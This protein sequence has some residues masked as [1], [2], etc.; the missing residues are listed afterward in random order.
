MML[1]GWINFI[2]LILLAYRQI[3]RWPLPVLERPLLIAALL[4]FVLI[5]TGHTLSLFTQLGN[6]WLTCSVSLAW[7]CGS[8]AILKKFAPINQQPAPLYPDFGLSFYRFT[9]PQHERMVMRLMLV[10]LGIAALCSLILVLNNNAGNADSISYRLPRAFW[11]VSHHSLLHPFDYNDRRVLFYPLNG[12]LLYVPL[13]TY[14]FPGT[15]HNIPTYLAW[16]VVGLTVYRGGR[17]MGA[18]RA[19]SLLATALITLT[20]NILVQ[21]TATNDEIL[22]GSALLLAVYA[23]IRWL[24]SDQSLYLIMAATLAGISIGT[25]LHIVFYIPVLLLAALLLAIAAWRYPARARI[26]WQ[27]IGVPRL[28]ACLALGTAM[29]APFV[30]Y[31]YASSG[32]FYFTDEFAGDFFNTHWKLRVFGQNTLI[33]LAELIFAPLGDLYGASEAAVRESFHASLNGFFKPLIEPYLSNNPADYHL[34]YRFKGV[35]LP[36]SPYYLEYSLWAGFGFLLVP[37]VWWQ[38]WRQRHQ[39]FG[40]AWLLLGFAPL[41]WFVTW[42]ASTLYMEGTP[43]YLAYYLLISAPSLLFAFMPIAGKWQNRLR[44]NLVALVLLTHL[45]IDINIYRLNEF[46]N[47]PRLFTASRLPYDWELMDQ[48]VINEIKGAQRIHLAYTR[49]GMS[50]FGIMQHNPHAF[51]D[52]PNETVTD[53]DKTLTIF[54]VPS[55][56]TWGF[57]PLYVA[58]KPQPGATFIGKMRGWGS[59]GVF[60]VGDGVAQRWPDRNRYVFFRIQMQL[61]PTELGINITPYSPGY[62]DPDIL[63]TRYEIRRGKELVAVRDWLANPT[64]NT[65]I[66]SENGVTIAPT[67]TIIARVPGVAG[68]EVSTQLDLTRTHEWTDDMIGVTPWIGN[69]EGGD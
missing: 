5:M 25:K 12:T 56:Q 36:V 65:A 28:I 37:L 10:F 40:Y 1:L 20:P 8:L 69:K 50:Y 27:K 44:W 24:R 43:T 29:I 45:I 61:A 31:N 67:I 33:Y 49:W 60:A 62:H 17:E 54:A 15:F 57:L 66:P 68:S 55:M 3:A 39:P 59:E 23:V 51:Y 30:L 14:G 34:Q 47:I 2:A 19:T 26:V 32:R 64:W 63:E 52:G 48:S 42:C 16:L 6:P 18:Q 41:I 22:A 35:T 7:L 13:V 38:V 46:R 11:Y 21:S 53:P 58:A 4:W 9:N